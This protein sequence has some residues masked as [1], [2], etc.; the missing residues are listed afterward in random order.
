MQKS[1]PKKPI[2]KEQSQSLPGLASRMDPLPEFDN[3]SLGSERLLRK[4]S[5][6]TGGHSGIGR[7]VAVAFSKQGADVA[8]IHHPTEKE[9]DNIKKQFINT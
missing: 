8:I 4:K 5:F 6:I 2:F 3:H 9:D 7:P 1:N